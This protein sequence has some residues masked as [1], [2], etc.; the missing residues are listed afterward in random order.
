MKCCLVRDLLPNYI[1]GLTGEEAGEEIRK[2][3]EECGDCRAVYERMSA[4]IREEVPEEDRNIDFLKDLR[5]RLR[6]RYTLFALGGCICLVGLL[7]GLVC[8]ARHHRIPIPYEPACMTTEI[9][10]AAPIVNEYGNAQWLDLDALDFED[11]KAVIEGE[12]ETIDL[13]RLR[14]SESVGSDDMVSRGRTIW[15]DGEPVRVIYYCYTRTLWNEWFPRDGVFMD[16]A[17]GTG[18][19]YEGMELYRAGYEAQKREIYYLPMGDLE[20]L[21]QLSDEAFDARREDAVLVWKGVI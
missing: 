9:Y 16:R 3:L 15:R 13:V 5:T 1:D 14:L 18:E 8:F 21:D 19:I 4:V 7:A 12:K 6:R 10:R 2:H 17:C 11:S 20:R